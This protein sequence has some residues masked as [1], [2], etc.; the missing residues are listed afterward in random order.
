[1]GFVSLPLPPVDVGNIDQLE[2][3]LLEGDLGEVAG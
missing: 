2:L 3:D 1:M